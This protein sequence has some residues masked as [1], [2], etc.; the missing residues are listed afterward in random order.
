MDHL[1]LFA[2]FVFGIIVIP[3][4]DMAFVLS[5][6]L[7]GGRRTGLAAVGGL[8]AGG[9]VHTAMGALGVGLL[10]QLFPAAFNAILVAGALYVAWMGIGLWRSPATMTD[11]ETGRPRTM[12]S[13][14]TRAMV[15]CLLNPKAYVFMVAVFPQFIRPGQDT[16]LAQ[17]VALGAI[18][19]VTQVL[20]YGAVA[21]GAA[22]LR[23]NL[24]DSVGAQS[25]LGRGV[26]ALLVGT[27]AWA[28]WTG[29]AAA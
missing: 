10:L 25:V 19:A 12:R 22:G 13:A 11:V 20:V 26:A 14:F 8:V 17:V 24:R 7:V 28:L 1:W 21:F 4:M 15:T 5:S 6:A 2:L 3:G 29:W 9:I 23:A 18:I 16:L 27:A